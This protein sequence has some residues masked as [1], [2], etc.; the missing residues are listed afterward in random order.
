MKKLLLLSV[1]LLSA[2][3]SIPER[4]RVSET[5]PLVE[6]ADVR[7]MYQGFE[8]MQARWGGLIAKV[9]VREKQTMMEVVN[10]DL[11]G[12]S[13]PKV[14]DNTQGRFRVYID[15]LLDPLLYKEGR[16]VTV[17]GTI[18]ASESGLIGEQEYLYP[19]LKAEQVYLWKEIKEV[20]I[21]TIH[22]PY[23]YY[24]HYWHYYPTRR[25]YVR[26]VVRTQSKV[27]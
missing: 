19:R 22:T 1:F 9:D 14:A 27:N 4:L 7:Q 3:N 8:G 2:C 13:R 16:S 17:L 21:N 10:F 20:R 24:P 23:W 12:S 18:E 6:F 5:T 11:E 25:V 15:G 26:P